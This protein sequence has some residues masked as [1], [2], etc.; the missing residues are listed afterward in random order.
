MSSTCELCSGTRRAYLFSKDQ[1]DIFRCLSCGH[2]AL[3]LDMS[4]GEL[5]QL[6]ETEFFS[7]GSYVDYLGDKAILQKN[8]RALLYRSPLRLGHD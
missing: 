4:D 6:Y 8:S 7:N 2:V 1:Y 5:A 3:Q